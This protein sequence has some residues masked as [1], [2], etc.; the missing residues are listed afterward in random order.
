MS[1]IQPT[2]T[3]E[4]RSRLSRFFSHPLTRIVL[5]PALFLGIMIVL[6]LT[7][8]K[9][10]LGLLG[11]D[12]DSFRAWQGLITIML[13]FVVYIAIMRVYERRGVPELSLKKL[14][15][16]GVM[17]GFLAA[18]MVAT[19]FAMLYLLGSY[20]IL[21]TGSVQ[22]MIVPAIWVLLL[23]AMEEFMFRGI[24][25]RLLEQWLGTIA[26]LL[27]SAA[28]FGLLHLANEHA[29]AI[30]ILSASLGGL[31]MGTLY[32]LTGR[33]W[34][35]I[36]FHASW[37]F[38]QAI[39][40][41]TVSGTEFFG[42]YFESVREGPEWLTGGPFGVENSILTMGLLF[43]VIALLL[44]RMKQKN[45]IIPRGMMKRSNFH[46]GQSKSD[47]NYTRT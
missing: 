25:Y 31:L 21:S 42:T 30:S 26:A 40:G 46:N 22:A 8:I 28:F 41:S 16:D 12:E 7:V 39:F 6:K 23:A 4:Q 1:T 29:D 36:F 13:M 45:L 38:T 44:L 2:D 18:I 24:V 47:A 15:P 9:P 32:S 37:N 33:L 14:I 5:E 34:I 27:L 11:F 3:D 17:G 20:R 43:I 35:P 10:G 19:I